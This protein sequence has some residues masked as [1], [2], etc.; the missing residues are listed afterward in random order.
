MVFIL[1]LSI[2]FCGRFFENQLFFRVMTD[3]GQNERWMRKMP[4]MNRHRKTTRT[5]KDLSL[6]GGEFWHTVFWGLDW[7]SKTRTSKTRTC[8]TRTSITRTSKTRT[9]KTRTSKTRTQVKRG[10]VKGGL[11]KRGLVKRGLV[12][13]G[14]VKR[15]L[16]KRGLVKRGLVKHGLVE[17]GLVKQALVNRIKL[18]GLAS[19]T[20]CVW[21]SCVF[22]RRHISSFFEHSMVCFSVEM[23]LQYSTCSFCKPLLKQRDWCYELC[24]YVSFF[25]LLDVCWVQSFVLLARGRTGPVQKSTVNRK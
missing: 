2:S 5:V 11:V 15:G 10:L 14:L 6:E 3:T 25:P 20:I 24:A 22:L 23:F 1:F 19:E 21:S 18:N 13:R 8:K 16:V 12:K 7:T 4:K 17:R 9:C